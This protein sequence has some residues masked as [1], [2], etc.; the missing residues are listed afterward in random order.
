MHIDL[1]TL[2]R[3]IVHRSEFLPDVDLMNCRFDNVTLV[4][5]DIDMRS[6]WFLDNE[7]DEI[8]SVWEENNLHPGGSAE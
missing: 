5:P 4:S 2:K 6:D 7:I 1:E 8:F 3:R